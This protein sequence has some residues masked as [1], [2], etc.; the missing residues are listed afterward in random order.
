[1]ATHIPRQFPLSLLQVEFKNARQLYNES[2]SEKAVD[3]APKDRKTMVD[4]FNER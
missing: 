1:M 2:Q 4:C 3:M